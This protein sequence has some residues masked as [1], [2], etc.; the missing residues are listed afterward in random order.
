MGI[1]FVV[2]ILGVL[3]SV[4]FILRAPISPMLRAIASYRSFIGTYGWTGVARLMGFAG[5]GFGGPHVDAF[6]HVGTVVTALSLGGLLLL[7]RR[8]DGPRLTAILLLGF[9]VVTAG[10]GGQYV[11][12]PVALVLARLLPR[13][14]PFYLMSGIF[15]A[16]FYFI[17]WIAPT[18]TLGTAVP[19]QVAASL[20]LIVTA[21]AAIPWRFRPLRPA[22][23]DSAAGPV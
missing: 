17:A 3:S 2:T 11:L 20:L 4:P 12:W 13:G 19:V 1:V 22:G 18:T 9:L 6:Q 15:A 5:T 7:F 16:V 8:E 10:F 14:W 23:A 21:V